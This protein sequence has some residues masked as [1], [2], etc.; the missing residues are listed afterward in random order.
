MQEKASVIQVKSELQGLVRL[1][2]DNGH[3]VI[4]V[5]KLIDATNPLDGT[6]KLVVYPASVTDD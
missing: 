1:L 4:M 2:E 3:S 6:I 5:E